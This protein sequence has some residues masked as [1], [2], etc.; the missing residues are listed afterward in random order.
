M[1]TDSP[2]EL[3]LKKRFILLQEMDESEKVL[4]K[5][6][7]TLQGLTPRIK[8]E[9]MSDKLWLKYREI[10][11]LIKQKAIEHDNILQKVTLL[12]KKYG[13]KMSEPY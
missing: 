6:H 10:E 5:L 9:A 4:D 11:T 12:E 2:I 13:I 8:V 1:Q 7:V 3:A